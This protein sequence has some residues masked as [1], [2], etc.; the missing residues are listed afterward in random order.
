MDGKKISAIFIK[1]LKDTMKNKAVLLQFILFPL[2][3]VIMDHSVKMED[4]GEHFFVPLFATMYI[5]MAPLTSMAS[6]LA[7]EKEKN[8]LRVL[9]LANVKPMEYLIGVGSYILLACMLGTGVF[10]VTGEYKGR[11]L[12]EFFL[13]MLV[14]ILLSMLLGAAIGAWSKNEMSA[15]SISVPVMMIFSFLPMIAMFNSTVKNISRLLWSGQ[16][17]RFLNRLGTAVMDEETVCVLLVNGAVALVLFAIA[18]KKS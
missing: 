13:I 15:T 7:E 17:N 1:Q 18:Y 8:T 3:V 6:I 12:L 4:M 14:G 2:L 9:F 5:G 10:A 11:E 16:I